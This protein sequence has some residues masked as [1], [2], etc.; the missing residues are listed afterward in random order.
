M[1]DAAPIHGAPRKVLLATDLSARC[2]RALER[3]VSLAVGWNAQLI[4]CTSLKTSTIRPIRAPT[5]SS[6]MA[7]AAG[8]SLHRKTTRSPG[9]AGRP[10]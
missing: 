7:Q 8:C 4:S 1:A 9:I 3:A 5:Y 6:V 2:D 10:G